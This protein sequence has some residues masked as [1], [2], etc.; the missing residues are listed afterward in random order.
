MVILETLR[1][2]GI[3]GLKNEEEI[4]EWLAKKEA[5]FQDS[6]AGKGPYGALEKDDDGNLDYPEYINWLYNQVKRDFSSK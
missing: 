2:E 1:T 3:S 4:N 5:I 6:V